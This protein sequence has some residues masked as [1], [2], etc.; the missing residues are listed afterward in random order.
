MTVYSPPTCSTCHVTAEQVLD[1]DFACPK[2]GQR[3]R[4]IRM[5][6]CP[7]CHLPSTQQ[8]ILADART[9]INIKFYAH[10]A[11]FE[12]LKKESELDNRQFDVE[13]EFYKV[14]M[15]MD[16]P[17]CHK[18]DI[19]LVPIEEDIGEW[20]CTNCGQIFAKEWINGELAKQIAKPLKC[21]RC[22]EVYDLATEHKCELR[23]DYNLYEDE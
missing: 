10:N 3:L 9:A 8:R 2:C 18:P 19:I 5:H 17:D 15:T 6:L 7:V 1:G 22:G 12:L 4:G 16:C 11:C 21:I 20:T 14:A 13:M 23:G